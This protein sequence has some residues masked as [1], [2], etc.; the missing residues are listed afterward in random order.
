MEEMVVL[1]IPALMAMLLVRLAVLPLRLGLRLL[2][3]G[4]SG[5]LCLWLLN[6]VSGFTGIAFSMNAVSVLCAGFL[7]LPGV[8][9]LALLAVM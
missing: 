2:L 3:H 4:G 6:T 1:L 8:G 5:F 9:L 7:G